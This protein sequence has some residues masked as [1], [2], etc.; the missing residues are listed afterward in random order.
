M[1]RIP[2]RILNEIECKIGIARRQWD[3]AVLTV[4]V[5]WIHRTAVTYAGIKV[6]NKQN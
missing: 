3:V 5:T 1:L 4:A 6:R 2:V